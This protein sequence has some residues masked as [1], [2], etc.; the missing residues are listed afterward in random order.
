MN[1][2]RV[3]NCFL[4]VFD[5]AQRTQ[6]H[7]VFDESRQLERLFV[8]DE[9]Y[10]KFWRNKRWRLTL[11]QRKIAVIHTIQKTNLFRERSAT[12]LTTFNTQLTSTKARTRPVVTV[13]LY[14]T[15]SDR[16][17]NLSMLIK[18]RTKSDTPLKTALVT[19]LDSESKDLQL[20]SQDSN[21]VKSS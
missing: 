19:Q 17:S 13:C 5:S 20:S 15:P 6:F 18:V 16:A 21:G 10:G 8:A 14:C 4:V 12:P 11:T 3:R 1:P 9:G 2:Q 7:W